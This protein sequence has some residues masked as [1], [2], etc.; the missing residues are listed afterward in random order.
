MSRKWE[1]S[2]TV[3]TPA[4]KSLEIKTL[5]NRIKDGGW[6]KISLCLLAKTTNKDVA[7]MSRTADD[8]LQLLE[9]TIRKDFIWN[10]H[11]SSYTYIPIATVDC[12]DLLLGVDMLNSL[13]EL[14][15]G[16]T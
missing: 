11:A 1:G 4:Q 15:F 7:C 8:D 2:Q 13:F 5:I 9:P 6:D 3:V 12:T 16:D 14:S 10:T